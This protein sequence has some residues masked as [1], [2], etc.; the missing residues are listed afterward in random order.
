MNKLAIQEVEGFI[1][2]IQSINPKHAEII[3]LVRDLFTNEN[4]ALLQEIKYGGLTFLQHGE[5]IGGIFPYKK[6]LSI[7]FSNGAE[8]TDPYSKLE[9]NGK[10]RRH[11]KIVTTEDIETKNAL[12]FIQ[13]SVGE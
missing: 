8:F 4:K 6:H 1:R 3:E 13:Q 7:E 10:K 9:G 12:Y 2:D 5:L 11:L